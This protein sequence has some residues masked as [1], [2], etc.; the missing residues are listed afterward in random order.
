MYQVD[1]EKLAALDKMERHPNY[2][3][4]RKIDASMIKGALSEDESTHTT[5]EEAKSCWF[6]L[7]T[8][9]REEM[10]ELQFE[11]AYDSVGNPRHEFKMDTEYKNYVQS[12]SR[13]EL[14]DH[15][16]SQTF[17]DSKV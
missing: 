1:D 17:D 10:L 4:R 16:R 15:I 12:V 7:F 6:Y 13:Q 2:N 3:N 8:K 9:F 14:F 5:N 11:E